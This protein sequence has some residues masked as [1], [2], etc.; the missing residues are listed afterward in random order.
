MCEAKKQAMPCTLKSFDFGLEQWLLGSE[1]K[2]VH[3]IH[4]GRYNCARVHLHS[5]EWLLN[6]LALVTTKTIGCTVTLETSESFLG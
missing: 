2:H 6:S 1:L 5:G 4:D 3:K